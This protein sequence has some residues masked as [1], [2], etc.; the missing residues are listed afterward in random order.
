MHY[1]SENALI[2]WLIT[3]ILS[4]PFGIKMFLTSNKIKKEYGIDVLSSPAHMFSLVFTGK[5]KG[6]DKPAEYVKS[7][8]LAFIGWNVIMLPGMVLFAYILYMMEHH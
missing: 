3:C 7:M 2:V 5:T 6:I 1:T 4:L 8:R